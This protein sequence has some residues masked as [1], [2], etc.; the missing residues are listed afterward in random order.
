M[1]VAVADAGCKRTVLARCDAA[2]KNAADAMLRRRGDFAEKEHTDRVEGAPRNSSAQETCN[3]Q[4]LFSFTTHARIVLHPSGNSPAPHPSEYLRVDRGPHA[5]RGVLYARRP[6]AP[7]VGSFTACTWR[8][9]HHSPHVYA[10]Q[11]TRKGTNKRNVAWHASHATAPRDCGLRLAFLRV[12]DDVTDAAR[13][14]LSSFRSR[15]RKSTGAPG[16]LTHDVETGG[17]A[18]Q[19]EGRG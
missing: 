15:L 3:P 12:V 18:G 2:L 9:H 14:C 4:V 5:M 11:R 7:L 10:S 16:V 6:V 8:R 1:C 13:S 17:G 19:P